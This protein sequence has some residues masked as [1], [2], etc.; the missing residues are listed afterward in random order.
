MPQFYNRR[1]LFAKL[2][3]SSSP[4][5]YGTAPTITSSDAIRVVD[6]SVEDDFGFT[7]RGLIV[8]HGG[9]SEQLLTAR[10]RKFTFKIELVGSG[11]AGTPPKADPIIQ[12]CGF[13]RTIQA[14]VSVT[15]NRIST[16][17]K[18]CGIQYFL[19]GIRYISNGVRG[20]LGP[21]FEIGQPPYLECEM[22]G[23]YAGPSDQSWPE[24][25]YSQP[26]PVVCNAANTPN[27]SVHGF[28]ACLAKLQ[29]AAGQQMVHR[30][31]MGCV[32]EMMIPSAQPSGSLEIEMPTI[33]AKDFY[34][35]ASDQSQAA[36]SVTHDTRPGHIVTVST[37]AALEVP[38]VSESDGIA[39]IEM[40][41]RPIPSASTLN[42]L[43]LAFT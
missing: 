32:E 16:G 14:G 43:V 24:Y 2:N 40:G 41:I 19:D 10:A 29:L 33:T 20:T 23:L 15:Y 31:L 27:V 34:T 5:V 37:N 35:V 11:T 26:D 28:A 13:A 25:T 18:D 8:P 9:N 12:A 42:D 36:I 4:Y 17:F 30:Q 38:K 22:M 3:P 7:D 6:L 39:H 21:S 1:L